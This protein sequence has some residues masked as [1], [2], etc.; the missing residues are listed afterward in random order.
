MTTTEKLREAL[1]T[2]EPGWT[3]VDSQ[4]V[5]RQ[6]LRVRLKRRIMSAIAVL[7]GVATVV[8]VGPAALR[9]TDSPGPAT[10]SLGEARPVPTTVAE[11]RMAT[12]LE[13]RTGPLP[14]VTVRG[15]EAAVPFVVETAVYLAPP[16]PGEQGVGRLCFARSAEG[17]CTRLARSA[18]GWATERPGVAVG[19]LKQAK[20]AAYWVV[21]SPV[22]AVLAT[23]QGRSVPTALLDLGQGYQL[24]V[25]ATPSMP[26]GDNGLSVADLERVWAF[27]HEGRLVA[28]VG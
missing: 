5:R 14:Q 27:D 10:A 13:A 24:A 16:V 23:A 17:Q 4:A 11:A 3:S 8:T 1:Q 6:A 7:A 22:A 9:H 15:P 19:N 25:V 26:Q 21:E 20:A 2:V 12:R 18:D 28:R